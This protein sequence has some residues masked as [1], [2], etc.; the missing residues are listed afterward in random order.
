M[1]KMVFRAES[2]GGVALPNKKLS[3]TIRPD[4]SQDQV[5]I[6][7]DNGATSAISTTAIGRPIWE[8]ELDANEIK[9]WKSGVLFNILYRLP[10]DLPILHYPVPRKNI[11]LDGT[12]EQGFSF[13][14]PG[15]VNEKPNG[16]Y[17][18]IFRLFIRNGSQAL[19]QL[20]PPLPYLVLSTDPAIYNNGMDGQNIAGIFN[21]GTMWESL[22]NSRLLNEYGFYYK[23]PDLSSINLEWGAERISLEILFERVSDGVI[24]RHPDYRFEVTR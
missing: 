10:E 6:Q 3:Y 20:L 7:K 15:T 2:R 5:L 21:E 11:K 1:G 14:Q 23:F 18:V 13:I 9:F 12:I 17:N 22:G 16:K 24:F 8:Q 4:I 19:H